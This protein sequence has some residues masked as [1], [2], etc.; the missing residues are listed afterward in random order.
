MFASNAPVSTSHANWPKLGVIVGILAKGHEIV[1][2]EQWHQ[3]LRKVRVEEKVKGLGE[4]W[5]VGEMGII[6]G[7]WL[8]A[9][10][11]KSP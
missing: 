4:C 2:R 5:E 9:V 1:S 3:M 7:V 6:I 11:G 10:S 8:E